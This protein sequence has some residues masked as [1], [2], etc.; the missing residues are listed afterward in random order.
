MRLA[1]LIFIARGDRTC[2]SPATWECVHHTPTHIGR[3]VTTLWTGGSCISVT[4]SQRSRDLSTI[5]KQRLTHVMFVINHTM[6]YNKKQ[7][8][9][10][11]WK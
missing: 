11:L 7:R 5:V 6:L 8:P 3:F 4:N 10:T 1:D 9:E 2:H